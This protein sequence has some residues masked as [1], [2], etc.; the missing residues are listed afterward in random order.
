MKKINLSEQKIIVMALVV[1]AGFILLWAFIYLPRLA[2]L[3][4]LRAKWGKAEGKIHQLESLVAQG[5]LSEGIMQLKNQLQQLEAKFPSKEEQGLRLLSDFA[6]KMNLEVLSVTSQP[7]VEFVDPS[8][9]KI[10][11]EGK[12]CQSISVSMDIKGG[13]KDFVKYIEA[14]KASLPAYVSF[15]RVQMNRASD[16][17][18]G[19]QLLNIKLELNVFLLSS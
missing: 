9:Q 3:N 17:T 12:T 13:Y 19:M 8:R 10:Q 6:R 11:V 2:S 18:A 16:T 5:D 15:E 1:G 4:E 14:L 7:K